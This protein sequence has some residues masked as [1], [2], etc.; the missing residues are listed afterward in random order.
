MT[1]KIQR[2]LQNRQRKIR[3]RL[4]K[5]DVR[6]C[7]QPMFTASNIHYEIADR[8]RGIASG[9]IGDESDSF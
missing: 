9:G 5:K 3:R 4:D 7:S 1:P 2:Q 8:V 6:D